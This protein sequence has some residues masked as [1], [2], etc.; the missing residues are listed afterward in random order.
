MSQI[1]VREVLLNVFNQ[2][3]TA[4]S[5]T[6]D[7]NSHVRVLSSTVLGFDSADSWTSTTS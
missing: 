7:I 6:K 2:V 3:L 1:P 4:L 5:N